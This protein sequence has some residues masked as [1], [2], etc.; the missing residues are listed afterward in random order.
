MSGAP[1]ESVYEVAT[2]H[3]ESRVER[4]DLMDALECCWALAHIDGSI[5]PEA[6]IDNMLNKYQVGYRDDGERRAYGVSL[7]G[8]FNFVNDFRYHYKR[9]KMNTD[10]RSIKADMLKVKVTF[11]SDKDIEL[12]SVKWQKPNANLRFPRLDNGIR[13]YTFVVEGDKKIA[14]EAHAMRLL[15]EIRDFI[16]AYKRDFRPD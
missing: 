12:A 2:K 10:K 8:L 16:E 6:K 14:A 13:P 4:T 11:V 5:V 3:Q 7:K 1:S 9:W 15:L